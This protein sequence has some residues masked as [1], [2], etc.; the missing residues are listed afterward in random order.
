VY[1]DKHFKHTVTTERREDD[2]LG[3]TNPALRSWNLRNH[4]A[5]NVNDHMTAV[6]VSGGA[7][8]LGDAV[9]QKILSDSSIKHVFATYRT[10]KPRLSGVPITWHKLDL[11]DRTAVL[12]L[13]SQLPAGLVIIHCA[14]SPSSY[15]GQSLQHATIDSAMNLADLAEMLHGKLIALSTDLVF[16]GK[17]GGYKEED[18]VCPI[19]PYG[20]NKAEMERQLLSRMEKGLFVV[21]V[22]TS[23]MLTWEP[24]GKHI[25]VLKEVLVIYWI[26]MN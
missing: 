24:P 16:D 15:G 21:I 4:G 1:R 20:E 19:M 3:P 25:V 7:G 9:L 17:R 12:D 18:P 10:T 23:V 6:L 14:V 11:C 8:E 2:G 22:R 26:V 5:I 13:A